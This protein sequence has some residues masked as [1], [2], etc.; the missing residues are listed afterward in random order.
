MEQGGENRVDD[1]SMRRRG[2][3]AWVDPLDPNYR[4]L[5]GLG[6]DLFDD[7][8]QKAPVAATD[9]D[10]MTLAGIQEQL[11]LLT[12]AIEQLTQQRAIKVSILKVSILKVSILQVQR[13][14]TVTASDR[15]SNI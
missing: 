2:A 3:P 10:H 11:L 9:P 5:T 8:Q 12:V 13:L 6:D 14:L 15:K 7:N 4:T 1:R